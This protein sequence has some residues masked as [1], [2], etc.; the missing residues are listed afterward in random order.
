MVPTDKNHCGL[1]GFSGPQKGPAERPERGHATFFRA[2]QKKRQKIVKKVSKIFSTL[3][4][5]FRAGHKTSKIVK[6]V[7]KIFSTLFDIFS[8]RAKNVKN[9]QKYFRHF[10]TFFRAG[11]KTSKI[12]P[13]GGG[14]DGCTSSC[15]VRRRDPLEARK[16]QNPKRSK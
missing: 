16:G 4:D 14:S 11:Q 12:A 15:L 5:I 2:G 13:F 1:F 7:S 3:F 8:R 9:R 6:K 10:S